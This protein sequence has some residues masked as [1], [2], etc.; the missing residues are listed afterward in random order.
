M[1]W[2]TF[3]KA[4]EEAP[5]KK[6]GILIY[7]PPKD[8]AGDHSLFTTRPMMEYSEKFPCVRIW[9]L[10]DGP[11]RQA[12]EITDDPT[13]VITD[14]FGNEVQRLTA[15]TLKDPFS[16]PGKQIPGKQIRKILKDMP[17]IMK[18]VEKRLTKRL[19]K[20]LKELENERYAKAIWTFRQV[21]DVK[22]YDTVK[23][24]E[25]AMEKALQGGEVAV[26][27]A[28]DAG[29]TDKEKAIETLKQIAKDYQDT[30][31]EDAAWDAID[32]LKKGKKEEEKEE[33]KEEEKEEK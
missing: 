5:D 4:L 31:V 22:G 21:M 7:F 10:A 17:E 32:R 19:E 25:E 28:L 8:P 29:E 11:L 12:W 23:R 1:Y 30:R 13:I 33:G 24:A 18:K 9:Y 20:G 3:A 6:T 16:L 27:K 15:E 14:W 26:R 2:V